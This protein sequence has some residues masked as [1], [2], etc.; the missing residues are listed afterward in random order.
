M[1]MDIDILLQHLKFST[2]H[3]LFTHHATSPA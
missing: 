3:Y 2:T 1:D